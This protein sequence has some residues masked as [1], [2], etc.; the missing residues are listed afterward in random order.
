MR[1]HHAQIWPS[2]ERVPIAAGLARNVA[3][4]KVAARNVVEWNATVRL[5]HFSDLHIASDLR[6]SPSDLA[7]KRLLGFASWRMRR[8]YIHRLDVLSM[9]A[10]DVRRQNPDHVV[11]TGD[12]TNISL[13]EEF[14]LAARW[15]ADF[16]EPQWVS[17]I[18]GNHD[19]YVHIPW[20]QSW[21]HWEAYMCS[22]PE[23]EPDPASSSSPEAPIATKAA[24]RGCFPYLRRRQGLAIIG[25]S[26]AVVTG[27]GMALGRLGAEQLAR[28]R[29]LLERTR[30]E[31]AFRVVLLHHPPVAAS[32]H[33]YKR[34]LDADAFLAMLA[35]TGAEL[36]LHG[37]DHTH[38]LRQL[39]SRYGNVAAIGTASASALPANGHPAAQY[40]L[41]RI[42]GS[43]AGWSVEM[44]VRGLDAAAGR[45]V[46]VSQRT[47]IVERRHAVTEKTPQSFPRASDRVEA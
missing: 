21:A 19:A 1:W 4:R 12:I 39:P 8:R 2:V 7:R 46:N 9:L 23:V 34:L 47:L 20:E 5:A 29:G 33:R 41:Y 17:V 35:E 22:D 16:G 18:P 28:A 38:R 37:H 15:L 14:T 11:I 30:E 25:L 27:P 24:S 10:D 26:T 32:G 13:Q 40:H 6:L 42:T 36:V 45:F 44:Q 31:G 43:D 3:A